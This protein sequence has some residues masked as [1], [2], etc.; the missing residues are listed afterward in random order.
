[1]LQ[2]GHDGRAGMQQTH[3][4]YTASAADNS[5]SAAGPSPSSPATSHP[6]N[7]NLT[8]DA[9]LLS[10]NITTILLCNHPNCFAV[11][12]SS[13]EPGPAAAAERVVPAPAGIEEVDPG[14]IPRK[15]FRPSSDE[16]FNDT[17]AF[18]D[19]APLLAAAAASAALAALLLVG[20]LFPL[21]PPV[22]AGPLWLGGISAPVPVRAAAGNAAAVEVE[23]IESFVRAGLWRA[24][25]EYAA[26]RT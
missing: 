26:R 21:L 5:A 1:M 12:L 4:S 3:R 7:N 18:R 24:W 11:A 20:L 6:R 10:S 9:G 25:L 23:T 19:A 8:A 15:L 17:P 16:P 22:L 2:Q 13:P 14:G